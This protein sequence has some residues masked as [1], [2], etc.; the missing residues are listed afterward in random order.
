M[1]VTLIDG[2]VRCDSTSQDDNA[3]DYIFTGDIYR[4]YIGHASIKIISL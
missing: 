2:T 4:T 1:C 3:D